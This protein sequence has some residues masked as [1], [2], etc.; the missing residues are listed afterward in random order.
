MKDI[1]QPIATLHQLLDTDTGAFTS[2]E[3]QLLRCLPAWINGTE[4]PKLQSVL[5]KYQS[6]VQQHIDTLEGF[7]KEEELN[8]LSLCNPVMQAHIAETDAKLRR[9]TDRDV[10]DACLLACV[11]SINHYKIS[12]YGTAAAFAKALGM[13]KYAQI[14]RE[15]EVNEKQ[16]DDRLTQLAEHEINPRAKVPVLMVP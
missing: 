9:C 16:I 1:T 6:F 5:Q 8:A 3:I 13:E 15:A 14:F 10:K 4:S 11:Q 12:I 2:A 7:I